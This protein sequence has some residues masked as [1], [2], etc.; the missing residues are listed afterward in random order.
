[1]QLR[2]TSIACIAV[3][4]ETPSET[5]N[6]MRPVERVTPADPI[7]AY[8]GKRAIRIH[9]VELAG[10]KDKEVQFSV[11]KKTFPVQLRN[12]KQTRFLSIT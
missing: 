11:T 10:K 4:N 8:F 5:S 1:M 9:L 2:H 6:Q 7:R 3:T 12:L